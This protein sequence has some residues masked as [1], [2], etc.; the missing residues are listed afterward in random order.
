MVADEHIGPLLPKFV[1]TNRSLDEF[2][3]YIKTKFSTYRERR[4]FIW[5]EFRPLLDGLEKGSLSYVSDAD[6][7]ARPLRPLSNI[8]VVAQSREANKKA[9]EKREEVDMRTR[10][11][12]FLAADPTSETRLRLG[13]EFRE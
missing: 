3:Q 10:S 13:Q 7:Q 2:W 9:V 11:I 8:K 12:L 6:G 5:G 1:I 4:E